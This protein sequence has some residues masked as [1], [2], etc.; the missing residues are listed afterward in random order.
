MAVRLLFSEESKWAVIHGIP[1]FV[2]DNTTDEGKAALRIHNA[3]S[4]DIFAGTQTGDYDLVTGLHIEDI[5]TDFDTNKE[6]I[7]NGILDSLEELWTHEPMVSNPF[8]RGKFT[9]P[10]MTSATTVAS[11]AMNVRKQW[12]DAQS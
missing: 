3:L 6:G 2:V 9:Q 8:P 4:D 1:N 10:T 7:W 5:A 12:K 11:L